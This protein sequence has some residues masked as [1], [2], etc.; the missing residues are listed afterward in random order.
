MGLEVVGME[1]LQDMEL[2][3][4]AMT[5]VLGTLTGGQTT[6]VTRLEVV[7]M[8]QLQDMELLLL[9]MTMVLGTPTGGQTTG[10]TR[11]E[12]VVMVLDTSPCRPSCAA[13]WT[14]LDANRT[15]FGQE[16]S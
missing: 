10:V 12:V 7:G 6:G 14:R 3:L 16:C 5:M 15:R 8:E 1:Q 9:A 2:I 11:L 4:L 13:F